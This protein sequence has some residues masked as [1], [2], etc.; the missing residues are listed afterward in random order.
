M[1]VSEFLQIHSIHYRDAPSTYHINNHYHTGQWQWYMVRHGEVVH[2]IEDQP[3]TIEEGHGIFIPPGAKRS[4]RS[5]SHGPSYLV[6]VFTVERLNL[7]PMSCHIA[8]ICDETLFAQ[9]IQE[10][11]EPID[12]N[13]DTMMEALLMQMLIK[14]L[15]AHRGTSASQ[16]PSEAG[17]GLMQ[18]DLCARAI[19]FMRSHL[20]QSISRADIA[21]AV[22]YSDPHFARVF[23]Q[24]MGVS[25][26]HYLSE[27][28]I[29]RA[30][31][32]LTTS[33][34]SIS[35]IALEVGFQSFSHFTQLFKQRTGQSPSAFRA[36]R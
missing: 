3:Y 4:P 14:Q 1:D 12:G 24:T 15:R 27:L 28:R 8:P 26:G 16:A 10:L 21:S 35:Q 31:L 2:T 19:S 29:E 20:H 13:A 36:Q 17:G 22:H 18:Q 34:L 9:L 23:R 25:P 6:V 5:V 33:T 7:E 32:F 11:N 30:K